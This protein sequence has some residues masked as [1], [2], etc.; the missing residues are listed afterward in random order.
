MKTPLVILFLLVPLSVLIARDYQPDDTLIYK[1]TPQGE[2]ALHVFYPEGHQANDKRP[3]IVFFFGG[4][5]VGGNPRQFYPQCEYFA[6]LGMVAFSAEYR[7]RS[8][9]NTSPFE[10]VQDGKSAIRWMRM[11][12]PELGI[13]PNQIVASGGS[14][15]GHVAACTGLVVGHE[16]PGEDL[17][18][19]SEPSAMILFNPVLDTT[20]KGYGA[21]KVPGRERAISPCHNV[22]P[23][24]APCLVFHGTNDKTVP[25]EN[26]KCFSDAMNE[27]G[28]L[29]HLV[30]AFGAG[31]GFFNSSWFRENN[32][33]TFF[34]YTMYESEVF[35]WKLGYLKEEPQW[36]F[37]FNNVGMPQQQLDSKKYHE[38]RD[39][40]KNSQIVFTREKKGRVAFLGGSITYNGGWRDSIC[41]YLQK[42]F[43]ETEF[44]FIAAGIPSMGTTP[45]AFRLERDVLSKGKIDLLFEE[46]AVNDASN[47]RSNT[48]QVRAM[49][50]IVRHLR[51]ENPEVDIVFMHFVDPD[52][53][54]MYR[55]GNVPEVIQNHEKVASH[56]KLPSLNLAQEVTERIDAG[57][58]TWEDDFKNLHPSPFGQGVYAHSMLAFLERAWSGGVADDDKV[59]MY[60]QPR[61]LDAENYANGKLVL[62]EEAKTG[63]DWMM[64]PHWQPTDG[65]G[66]RANYVHVPMLVGEKAGGKVVF[67]F[68]GRAV[69]IA[70]AAGPDAGIIEYKVDGGEWQKL[71]LFTR[72][73]MHLHLPW[74]YTLATG[75]D[76]GEHRLSIRLSEEKNTKSTGHAC[77]IRYFY[78]NQ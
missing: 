75:L 73:S 68:A 35:L 3:A 22:S 54:E 56:Y 21:E 7:I 48:E 34:K 26:A 50:G 62:A 69:G 52:K 15:G 10:C 76:E 67:R 77:R 5:W 23:D 33:D 14:A 55:Q 25:Y 41:N 8:L 49:E 2:L 28:N 78:V 61:P 51:N 47:G 74:Y 24:R 18:V 44:E 60:K 29:C 57:E 59:T 40:L 6:S 58:F 9:H 42:R 63:K 38:M 27:A 12:A 71:D 16:E 46:A 17:S 43:P 13:N 70:V 64:I 36:Q 39:G 30:P 20:E 1:Q 72:W 32:S 65:K 4:G 45:A 19:S 37:D 66:T 31:H 53:M 11:T